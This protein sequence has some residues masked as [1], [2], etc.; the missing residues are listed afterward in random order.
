MRRSKRFLVASER[1]SA[2]LEFIGVGVVLLIPLVYLMLA[3]GAIQHQTLGAEA[4]ARHTA[5]AVS[6]A[7]SVA[8]AQT[9]SAAVLASVIEEYGM[10]ENA[11]KVKL[12]CSTPRCPAAGATVRVVVTT[13]VTLPFAPAIFGLDQLAK[14]PIRAEAIQKVSGLWGG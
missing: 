14:I 3:L 6:Q 13:E 12:S 10:N 9:R 4:A 5:R 11:V 2:A 7:S 1:G 8:N